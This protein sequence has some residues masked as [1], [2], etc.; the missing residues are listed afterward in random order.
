MLYLPSEAEILSRF[1]GKSTKP[2]V[3]FLCITY[4]QENY[5]E[6]TIK[7]FLK[8]KTSFPY[9][10]LI[11][12]DQSTDST[13]S[14]IESYRLRYPNIM[15]CIYQ[16]ENQYSKGISPIVI[17]GIECISVYVALCEGDDYWINEKK[18]ENQL[19]LIM[20]DKSISMVV[21]PGKLEQDGKILSELHCY[22][23][24]KNQNVNAQDI[25]DITGQFAP[26]AS[27]LLKKSF[28]IN[29]INMF[30]KAPV[31]DTFIELYSAVFGK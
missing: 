14:I 6:Q 31:D 1:K 15:R 9:E 25:L 4:N 7:G 23:G 18:I 2:L 20:S 29:A 13:K 30:K 12:D 24:A 5:I 26:T 19:K 3:T 11:H 28:L 17:A 16:D 22:Y 21:S 8:Q 27:Y 10:I